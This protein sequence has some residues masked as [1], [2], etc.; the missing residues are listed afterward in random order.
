MVLSRGAGWTRCWL[1]KTCH[2]QIFLGA[3]AERGIALGICCLGVS[4]TPL[5]RV[6]RTLSA[7][8]SVCHSV[9]K[10]L[11]TTTV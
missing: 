9:P 7:D 3:Y 11:A 10:T 5:P 6:P 8:V 1:W 4:Y 2:A